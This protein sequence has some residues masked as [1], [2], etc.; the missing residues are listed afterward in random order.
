MALSIAVL[1]V[2]QDA[3]AR[4]ASN[5]RRAV[6]L[7]AF[8][9]LR[10]SHDGSCDRTINGNCISTWNY[11]ANDQAAYKTVKGWYRCDSS[12]WAVPGDKNQN[13]GCSGSDSDFKY[14]NFSSPASFYSNVGS[15]GY[16]TFGGSY[17][18][19]GRGGECKFF[20]NL[21]LDRSGAYAWQF[22]QYSDMWNNA[23]TDWTKVKEGDVI[24]TL[25]PQH[26]AVVVEIKR[27]N[28]SNVVGIDVIDSNYVSDLGLVGGREAIGRHLFTVQVL[29]QKSYRIWKGV[30]YYN[31]TYKP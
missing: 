6:V 27:D 15:Y 9:A 22:P 1:F 2:P 16:G 7:E 23:S 31:E 18:A 3:A 14:V 30:N 5:N 29:Q 25:S 21:I 26:T 4:L 8:Y 19:L 28:K 11:L 12:L 13:N 20:A 24:L 10:P 17:G